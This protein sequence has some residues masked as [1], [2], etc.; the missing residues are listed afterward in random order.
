LKLN[1]EAIKTD[2]VKK[3][4]KN[5]VQLGHDLVDVADEAIQTDEEAAEITEV[6]PKSSGPDQSTGTPT[7]KP[8]SRG[9]APTLSSAAKPDESGSIY[10][11]QSNDT[12]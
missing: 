3:L 5:I 11:S 1:A 2:T 8:D 6:H 4:R 9:S 10:P 12:Q 7:V